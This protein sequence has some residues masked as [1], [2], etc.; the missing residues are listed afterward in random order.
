MER[1]LQRKW[2]LCGLMTFLGLIA[3]FLLQGY[4]FSG[5]L[6]LGMAALIPIYHGLG[7][8]RQTRPRPGRWLTMILT[9]FLAVLFT[10]MTLTCAVIVRSSRGTPDPGSK[11]LVVLGAA[12]HGTVPSRSLTER[13]DGAYEYLVSHPDATAILSGGQGAGEDITEARCMFD[14]LTAKG[15]EP[16]RLWMEPRATNTLENLKFSLDLI[17]EKTG[18]RP[19]TVAIVSS[20][21]HLHRAGIFARQLGLEPELVRAETDIAP[22]RWNYFLREIFAVWYYTI[23]GR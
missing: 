2:I 7:I 10:A 11:Y 16:Q 21:Y 15:I 22:L 14:Y 12:V 9:L 6:F 19:D 8:L 5:Y 1:K 17:E 13:M 4:D 23:F 18:T 20:E 3:I